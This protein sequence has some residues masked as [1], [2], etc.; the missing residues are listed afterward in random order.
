M[1]FLLKTSLKQNQFDLKA[2][3]VGPQKVGFNRTG[4]TTVPWYT[5]SERNVVNVASCMLKAKLTGKLCADKKATPG[6]TTPRKRQKVYA[7][8]AAHLPAQAKPQR[9]SHWKGP[10]HS[11][12][13]IY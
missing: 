1:R 7:S 4:C 13:L 2:E 11:S 9:V 10:H 5:C 3:L 8:R 6:E 12:V